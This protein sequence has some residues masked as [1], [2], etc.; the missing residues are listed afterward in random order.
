MKGL[1]VK[2]KKQKSSVSLESAK[3]LR[4]K[5]A[6]AKSGAIKKEKEMKASIAEEKIEKTELKKKKQEPPT[7]K[8][9]SAD[10]EMTD[11]CEA[12]QQVEEAISL[13]KAGKLPAKR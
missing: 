6:E 4:Q 12:H 2:S 3:L 1:S 8:T 13:E 9:K 5:A 7:K 10:V 11:E